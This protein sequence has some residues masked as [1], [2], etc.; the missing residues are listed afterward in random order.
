[1]ADKVIPRRFVP[2]GAL[3][4]HPLSV[5]PWRLC[6]YNKH[7]S[8]H[9]CLRS[10]TSMPVVWGWRRRSWKRV[11]TCSLCAT[12][13]LCTPRPQTSSLG[14]LSSH[15]ML[16][17][18][19]QT[20]TANTHTLLQ[21]VQTISYKNAFGYCWRALQL[22]LTVTIV[23][24]INRI[25]R[26]FF[27]QNPVKR[28]GLHLCLKWCDRNKVIL[29]ILR[30]TCSQC[31]QSILKSKYS[32]PQLFYAVW[33]EMPSNLSFADSKYLCTCFHLVIWISTCWLSSIS[34]QCMEVK[35]SGAQQTKTHHQRNVGVSGVT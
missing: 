11:R 20:A 7:A 9:I 32:Y 17:V 2:P 26:L 1:M 5:S 22:F 14:S 25:M 28:F 15:R 33:L 12:H 35:G 10:N 23:Y 21:K 4:S 13:C 34:F 31:W 16:R 18:R 27:S 6:I 8:C 24:G 3:L 29:I 30:I 19:L